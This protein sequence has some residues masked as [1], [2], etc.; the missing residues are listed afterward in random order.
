[1]SENRR[2]GITHTVNADV[3]LGGGTCCH[4]GGIPIDRRRHKPGMRCRAGFTIVELVVVIVIIGVITAVAI[5][6]FSTANQNAAINA[7]AADFR[8]LELA[9]RMYHADNGGFPPNRPFGDHPAPLEPYYAE[10]LWD[11]G[12]VFGRVWDWN[13]DYG[14][15]RPH[16]SM[17]NFNHD[18]HLLEGFDLQF[19]D[20]DPTAGNVQ[21]FEDRHF[22]WKIIP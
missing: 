7:A 1:M 5:P 16:I 12:P 9:F 21:Y 11:A 14:P 20:G 22:A 3:S 4:L 15:V 6:R 17:F 18:V 2:R 19:D 10:Q 13:P 8:N